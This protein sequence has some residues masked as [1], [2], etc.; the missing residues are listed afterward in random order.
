MFNT[1]IV[2]NAYVVDD[3]GWSIDVWIDNLGAG[4]FFVKPK[5]Q[6]TVKYRGQDTP[7]DIDIALGQVGSVQIELIKINRTQDNVYSDTYPDGVTCGFHHVAIFPGDVD[8]AIA[9]YEGRGYPVAMDLM[10]G[11]TRVVYMDTRTDM[12]CMTEFYEDTPDIRSLYKKVA[13][14]AVNWDGSDR[15]RPL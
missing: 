1:E 13:D 11:P 9:A 6:L 15:S 5:L 8:A 12:G 3:L 10:F 14:A 4:P 7:L 2:Q